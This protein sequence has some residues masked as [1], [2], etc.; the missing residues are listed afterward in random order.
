MSELAKKYRTIGILGGMG[1]E[2]TA[3]FLSQIIKITSASR[4]QE[5]V[6]V[7]VCSLP[8]TPDRTQAVLHGGPSPLPWLVKGSRVL[9]RAGA[10]FIVIPCLTAHFFYPQLTKKSPVPVI[11]LIE[12]T[13]QQIIEHWPDLKTVGLIATSGTIHSGIFQQEFEKAG[14]N[15]VVPSAVSLKQVMK[16]IYGKTGVKAGFTQGASRQLIS[17]VARKLIQKGAESIVAGCTEIPL[18]L[19]QDDLSVPLVDPMAVGAWLSVKKAGG[20]VRFDPLTESRKTATGSSFASSK[21]NLR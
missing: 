3:N 10:D 9:A 11:N 4:D 5:H 6:P 20:R 8:Q 15:V 16:A 13:V 2:A 17:D 21:Q 14:L 19:T 12:E 18:V 7:V 1:P